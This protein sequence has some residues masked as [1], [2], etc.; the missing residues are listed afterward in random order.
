M[1]KK[2]SCEREIEEKQALFYIKIDLNFLRF[3]ADRI[4][5]RK[6]ILI[7]K[8]RIRDF[9]FEVRKRYAT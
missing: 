5:G 6:H 2:A 8:S 7:Q 9:R 4:E 3:H 1:N